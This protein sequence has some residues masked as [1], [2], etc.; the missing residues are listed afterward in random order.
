MTDTSEAV[1]DFEEMVVSRFTED[2]KFS[3]V[4]SLSRSPPIIKKWNS[5]SGR[6]QKNR[7]NRLCNGCCN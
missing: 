2:D 4:Q 5:R 6:N 3:S 7:G 1:S